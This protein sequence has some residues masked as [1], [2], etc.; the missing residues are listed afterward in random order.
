MGGIVK[1]GV[2]AAA[3]EG[4]VEALLA[5]GQVALEQGDHAAAFDRFRAAARSG[6]RRAYNMLGRCCELGW[7]TAVD[8]SQAAAYY[9]HAAGLGDAWAKFNLADLFVRGVGVERDDHRAFGLYAEAARLGHAK[10]LNMLGLFYE[11]GRCV[12]EDR[13]QA[14]DFY[15]AGARG[16]DC[17]AQ[18]NHARL[19]IEDGML[20][21]AVP[22]LE[23]ALSS[24]FPV[25]WRVLGAAL[26]RQADGRLRDIARRAA[27]ALAEGGK[28]AA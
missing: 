10:S 27:Q 25:F 13:A 15:L 2:A 21:C 26:A 12:G 17:W 18:F 7:G 20:E 6:D 14:G 22:W 11:Q 28:V 23:R 3:G 4:M 9:R 24:G 16:G 1:Q 19:L 5:L 8:A